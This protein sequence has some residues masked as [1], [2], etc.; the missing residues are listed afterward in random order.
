MSSP[1]AVIAGCGE[2]P[3]TRHPPPGTTTP[4]V[5]ADAAARALASAGLEPSSLD[6]LAVSSFSLAPDHAVDLAWRLGLRLHWLMQDT[7]GGASGINMLQHAARAVQAGDARAILI[8]AGDHLPRERFQDLVDNYNQATSDYLAPL[9][10]GGPNS[11]FAMLTQRH[12]AAH[13]LTRSDY[14]ALVV[15][16]R[17]WAG[18][19]PGAAY[20]DPMQLDDYLNAPLVA[21]PLCV[22]DC[23]PVVSGA[24]AVVICA[25]DANRSGAPG[26]AIRALALS[27]NPDDQQGDGLRTGLADMADQLW[28]EAGT[29]P[30]EI[31]VTMVYDDYPAMALVQL[32]DLGYAG[33]GD[34]RSMIHDH[35]ATRKTAVNTSGG[36]LSAGQAGAAGGLHGVVEAV[37]Q[38]R[39]EAGE[40]QV[41]GARRAL[42]AGYGMVCYR[43]GACAGATVLEK[44]KNP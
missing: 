1:L 5:L 30:D 14:G 41:A 29:D 20:R 40:R 2:S 32:A 8:V 26:V 13:G 18:G 28:R 27:I 4:Q 19:N 31:D 16:Q 33:D 15:A 21:D 7:N 12:A 3:Y 39:G 23:V 22:Y 9:P 44:I 36:Q 25:P 10:F 34:V 38:L 6:G 37:H 43:Y 17:R 24:D 42:V 35:I 11:L